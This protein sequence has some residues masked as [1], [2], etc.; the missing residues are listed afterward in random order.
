MLSGLNDA[1]SVTAEDIA[2]LIHL[3]EVSLEIALC[4]ETNKWLSFLPP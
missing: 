1:T 2:V 3:D 4:G